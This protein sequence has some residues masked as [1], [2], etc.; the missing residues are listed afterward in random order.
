MASS[1][2]KPRKKPPTSRPTSTSQISHPV[3]VEG[4]SALVSLSSFSP[5]GDL[6]AFVSLAVDK[7]RLRV[8]DTT[9]AR[10]VAEHTVD[11]SRVTTLA[12][13]SIDL[14]EGQRQSA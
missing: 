4:A 5:K 11:S 2:K 9:S 8:F 3:T 10:S 14:S 13:S 7:H 12:W 6:F 1:P